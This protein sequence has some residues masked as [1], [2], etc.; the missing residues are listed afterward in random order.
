M[1]ILVS[2]IS[3]EGA[4]PWGLN[5]NLPMLTL[6]KTTIADL[7]QI[8]PHGFRNNQIT[9]NDLEDRINEKYS[10][11]VRLFRAFPVSPFLLTYCPRA[12]TRSSRMSG[13]AY[14]CTISSRRRT[15]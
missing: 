15:A 14:A 3:R 1:F 8:P 9:K 7:V 11:K 5:P 10:N 13:Y 2:Q 4:R 12:M 6:S